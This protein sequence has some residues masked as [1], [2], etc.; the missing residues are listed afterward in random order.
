MTAGGHPALQLTPVQLAWLREIGMDRRQLQPYV[1]RAED[2]SSAAPAEPAQ[3]PLARQ[4]SAEGLRPAAELLAGQSAVAGAARPEPA[5]GTG[6]ARPPAA[7]PAARKPAK[8][9]TVADS[10]GPLPL[11]WQALQ[12][13]VA[14]CEA[15]SLH[16]GR[17]QTVFGSGATESVDWM[18]IGEAPGDRDDRLGQPFQGKAGELLGAM[19]RAAGVGPE[20]PVFYT[21]LIKCR[22][23]G[24]RTPKP[25]EIAAC[26]PYLQRQIAMLK[27][28]RILTLG[29][30]AA[31]ALLSESSDLEQLRG[32]VHWL[33]AEDG[34]RI[35][36]VA[37][38]HP[39]SLLS[40]ARHKA[41]AWRD[42]N[43]ARSV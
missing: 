18:I 17:S 16:A 30:L 10:S 15:C 11:D 14:A 22:P 9:P 1:R 35:P 8:A 4:A 37:T 42:L 32:Q 25:E 40:R 24:G 13:H 12:D 41:N 2:V 7:A 6:S 3:E 5:S 33:Q 19:L 38:Y 43:L 21:N 26:R 39:A 20:T 36:V 27:P 31:Q 28:H 34:R 29:W 23:R